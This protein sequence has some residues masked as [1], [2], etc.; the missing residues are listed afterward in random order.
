MAIALL[1]APC[2]L[3]HWRVD[4]IVRN[5]GAEIAGVFDMHV[6]ATIMAYRWGEHSVLF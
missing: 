1:H 5:L 6:T 3:N 2:E 4:S